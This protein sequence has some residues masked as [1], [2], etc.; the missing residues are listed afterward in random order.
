MQRTTLITASACCVC[1]LCCFAN[2]AV[3]LAQ[4]PL[5]LTFATVADRQLKLDLY[6][7][8]R[9][10]EKPV[11][12]IVWVHGGAWRAGSKDQ[13][14]VLHW[15]QCGYAIASVE[16]R[17]SP[18]ARFPA[19][20]HDIKAAIRFLRAHADRYQLDRQRFVIAGASAGGHLAALVGVTSGVDALE[21]SVGGHLDQSSSVQATVSFY[22]ASNLQ[23]I[24][25]QSTPHGLSVRVPALQ[26]L[27]GGQPNEQPALARLASPVAHVDAQDPPLWL[28][29]GNADP[30][31]PFEQSEELE[32]AYRDQSL[33]VFLDVVQGGKHGGAEFFEADRLDGLA[34]QIKAHFSQP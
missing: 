3:V 20:V 18:E 15:L 19:Q 1:L 21:G 24:L 10:S 28:I 11:P 14:P 27:L 17:L 26:L 4:G 29:H 6:Q 13:V 33:K 30:Q 8:A 22:G 12:T 34:E 32:K 31:M 5:E 7:R 16:Y 23:S 25:S 2:F 9:A